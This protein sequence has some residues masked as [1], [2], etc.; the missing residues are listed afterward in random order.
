MEKTLSNFWEKI[1][2]RME[3]AVFFGSAFVVVVFCIFGG[4]F[5]DTSADVFET[6]QKW[7]STNLGSYYMVITSGFLLFTIWLG[8]GPY[9]NVKLGPPDS[10]PDYSTFSWLCMLFSAGMGVGIVFWGVAEPITHYTSPPFAQ[11]ETQEAMGEAM[12]YSFFHWGLHPW[13]IYII[14][15]VALSYFHFRHKLPLAPRA[16][17]YPLFGR[18]IME[19]GAGHA[20]DILCVVGTLLGVSTSLG[21]GA[22][23][24]NS[25]MSSFSD[26]PTDKMTQ[27]S[28]IGIITL[29][30]TISVVVGLKQ[31]IR[32]LSQ[33]NLILTLVLLLFVFVVGPTWFILQVFSTSLVEYFQYLPQMS[34]FDSFSEDS[35]WQATWTYY[36]WGWWISWSP[37][38][39]IFIARI[40]KGRTIGEFVFYVL[41]LPSVFTFFWFS[42]FGGTALHAQMNGSEIA[43]VVDNDVGF[44]L[45]ALLQDLPLA[46]I[47]LIWAT[48]AIM[49]FFITSSDSGSFVDDMVTS[50]GHP[51][52]AKPQRVFW[53]VSE[54]AVAATLLFVGGLSAIQ[55]ASIS[56]GAVMSLVL[57][58]ACFAL[59]KAL[60]KDQ[61]KDQK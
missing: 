34:L 52:P 44:S 24:V 42:T 27:I 13:A 9:R 28:L 18:K 51:N 53:A 40:S 38:V 54:G 36:Y 59:I 20:I 15:G 37:F 56:M 6:A 46:S 7:V 45:H 21:L 8:L 49:V 58:L 47:T 50:G 60:R 25:G 4:F 57:V 48:L 35:D 26:L 41:L 10:K 19:G 1:T 29:I 33:F 3:P 11:A 30:A 61:G 55:N 22:M 23:Q 39:G 31:G 5:T 14:L 2:A 32:R 16:I 43:Q 12:R 17:L